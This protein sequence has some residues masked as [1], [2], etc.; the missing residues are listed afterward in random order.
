MVGRNREKQDS[1]RPEQ[2]N[3][4]EAPSVF[5]LDFLVSVTLIDAKQAL[6]HLPRAG[7]SPA[8]DVSHSELCIFLVVQELVPGICSQ[9]RSNIA[10]HHGDA[11]VQELLRG[12]E[13]AWN[14]HRLR[15]AKPQ[16]HIFGK[17]VRTLGMQVNTYRME[18]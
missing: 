7:F 18:A 3:S 17:W 13:W 8:V 10:I 11:A 15:Q 5:Y 16:E 12:Q 14:G 9:S 2:K 1:T 6:N 4:Q